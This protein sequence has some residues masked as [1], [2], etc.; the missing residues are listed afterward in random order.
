MA[1]K[2][3]ESHWFIG[4]VYKV[5]ETLRKGIQLLNFSKYSFI[6]F[7]LRMELLQIEKLIIAFALRSCN[8]LHCKHW[9]VLW[10]L[11][12]IFNDIFHVFFNQQILDFFVRC[13]MQNIVLK[14][15]ALQHI[16]SKSST[17]NVDSEC[18]TLIWFKKAILFPP[19]TSLSFLHK[20]WFG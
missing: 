20:N 11:Q 2:K 13:Y 8:L 12:S 5:Q 18:K 6:A 3:C 15:F 16:A 10:C 19:M 9:K 1:L 7:Q 14:S 4:S 17:L